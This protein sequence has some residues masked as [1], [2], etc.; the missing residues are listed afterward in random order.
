MIRLLSL[1]LAALFLAL[2]LMSSP[3]AEAGNDRIAEEF[4][5]QLERKAI[6]RYLQHRGLNGRERQEILDPDGEYDLEFDDDD[7]G[8]RTVASFDLPD[9]VGDT[10]LER[11]GHG[12]QEVAAELLQ[13]RQIEVLDPVRPRSDSRPRC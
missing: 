10:L 7:P 9:H 2:S 8:A 4:I 13:T 1:P 3:P 11:I 5:T 6:D 12:G